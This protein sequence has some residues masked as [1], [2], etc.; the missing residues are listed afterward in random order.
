V[1]DHSF[2]KFPGNLKAYSKANLEKADKMIGFGC[3]SPVPDPQLLLD[4]RNKKVRW[5][6]AVES[7]DE[8]E[9]LILEGGKR[10]GLERMMIVPDCGFGGMRGYFKDDTGQRIAA[11]KLKNMVAAANQ[12][13]AKIS[14]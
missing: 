1:L 4:I 2:K 7:T 9:R 8:I 12:V 6:Q 14:R 10:F 5:E 11:Q 13:R 3:I